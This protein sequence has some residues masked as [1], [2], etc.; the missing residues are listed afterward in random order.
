MEVGSRALQLPTSSRKINQTDFLEHLASRMQSHSPDIFLEKR[1]SLFNEP[2]IKKINLEHSYES[3]RALSTLPQI[4]DTL[5]PVPASRYQFRNILSPEKVKWTSPSPQDLSLIR[6]SLPLGSA[7]PY[8]TKKEKV[9]KVQNPNHSQLAPLPSPSQSPIPPNL[10]NI[11]MSPTL[12]ADK[13]SESLV[14]VT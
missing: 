12:Q 14:K 1:E 3:N 7:G 5:S 11:V 10:Q 9:K 13:S 4:Q 8:E 2:D 6:K